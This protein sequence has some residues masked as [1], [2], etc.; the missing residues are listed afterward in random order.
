MSDPIRPKQIRSLNRRIFGG[1]A[2]EQSWAFILGIFAAGHGAQQRHL[3]LASQLQIFEY[4]AAEL[5]RYKICKSLYAGGI[6]YKPK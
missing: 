4:Q 6:K 3:I 1:R 5:M 2:P